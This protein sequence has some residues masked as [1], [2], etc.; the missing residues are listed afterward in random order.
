MA[1]EL[2]STRVYGSR[3]ERFVK[4]LGEAREAVAK[5][6]AKRGREGARITC[7]DREKKV[8][9]YQLEKSEH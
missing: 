8:V 9:Y 1:W 7:E 3:H 5:D 2:R 4:T 6:I